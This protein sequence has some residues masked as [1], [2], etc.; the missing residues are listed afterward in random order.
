MKPPANV[1]IGQV[2]L[3]EVMVEREVGGSIKPVSGSR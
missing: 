3:A 1:S 2:A